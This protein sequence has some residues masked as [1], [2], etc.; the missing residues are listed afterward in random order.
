MVL[1]VSGTIIFTNIPERDHAKDRP[2]AG[3]LLPSESRLETGREDVSE[4]A[5]VIAPGC[6]L[7]ISRCKWP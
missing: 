7:S 6:S 2:C 4:D 1:V 3:L 5:K